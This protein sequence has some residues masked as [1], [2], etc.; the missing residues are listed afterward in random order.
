MLSAIVCAW[1]QATFTFHGYFGFR[2]ALLF[3]YWTQSSDNFRTK[4]KLPSY[5]HRHILCYK[6]ATTMCIVAVALLC[7]LLCCFVF[8][9]F[10]LKC[11]AIVY[12]PLKSLNA[13][14]QFQEWECSCSCFNSLSFALWLSLNCAFPSTEKPY[15]LVLCV[16]A[17]LKCLQR[18]YSGAIAIFWE[19]NQ[20]K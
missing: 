4:I 5:P 18:M 13:N 16:I 2:F 15:R 11:F 7:S 8:F 10:L 14:F 6:Y 1:T 9:L 17:C 20:R 12:H 19:S 3:V